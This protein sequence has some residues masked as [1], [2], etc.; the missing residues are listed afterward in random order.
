MRTALSRLFLLAAADAALSSQI[1]DFI[2]ADLF[3]LN[4]KYRGIVPK[5]S[6]RYFV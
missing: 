4:K 1:F 2:G 6:P 5:Y 3:Y